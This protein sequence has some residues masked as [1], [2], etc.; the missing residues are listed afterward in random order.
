MATPHNS[1]EK[2]DFAKTVLMP[3]DPLRAKF[4]AENFLTDV[5]SEHIKREMEVSIKAGEL[6]GK[7]YDVLRKQYKD[8]DSPES[9]KS[10]NIRDRPLSSQRGFLQAVRLLPL[11][12]Y[13]Y[14]VYLSRGVCRMVYPKEQLAQPADTFARYRSA[15]RQRHRLSYQDDQQLPRPY[16]RGGVLCSLYFRNNPQGCG[17]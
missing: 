4:I 8:S 14:S 1:A 13:T 6:V 3:G 10:L 16:P 11:L 15:D 9:L 17:D 2:G 7:I 12:V 5:K